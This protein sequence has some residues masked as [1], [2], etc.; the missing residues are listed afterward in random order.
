MP[1]IEKP[2]VSP[3]VQA[4]MGA[5]GGSPAFG[6]GIG[7][8]MQQ[9]GK[10]PV[11][12]AVSTVE[13]ILMGVQD[14]KFQEYAKKAIALLKVGAAMAQQQ[15]PQSAGVGAPPQPGEGG[16]PKIPTPPMPGQMPG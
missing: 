6:Q 5:P 16:A 8:A 12:T 9:Q 10:S 4:Q 14:E 3:Q 11:E 15:G 2:P 7:Q 13:K 1:M